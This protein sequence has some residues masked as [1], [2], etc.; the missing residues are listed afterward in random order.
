MEYII[1]FGL[2]V[3]VLIILSIV[4]I[5]VHNK[6]RTTFFTISF[7]IDDESTLTKQL[8]KGEFV[9]FFTPE[10]VNRKFEGWFDNE[11]CEG[12][13]FTYYMVYDTDKKFYAK[14]Y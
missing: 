12:S 9:E 11:D 2:G 3:S 14:W 6:N 13:K 1:S 7:V 4:K 8:R 10:K 5:N